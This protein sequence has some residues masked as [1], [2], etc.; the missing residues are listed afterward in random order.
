MFSDTASLIING[1]TFVAPIKILKVIPKHGKSLNQFSQAPLELNIKVLPKDC[2]ITTMLNILLYG[3]E[4]LIDDQNIL[5]VMALTT[6]FGMSFTNGVINYFKNHEQFVC[7]N[8]LECLT[9]KFAYDAF[10]IIMKN[11]RKI[12]N[13][14][15][16][17]R[18]LDE[19]KEKFLSIDIDLYLELIHYDNL[20]SNRIVCLNGI[21]KNVIKYNPIIKRSSTKGSDYYYKKHLYQTGESVLC[22][23]E[24]VYANLA[25][26]TNNVLSRNIFGEPWKNDINNLVVSGSFMLK[27]FL[28]RGNKFHN[29]DI[30][31]FILNSDVALA[32]E[33]C[34]YIAKRGG[35]DALVKK[36][37]CICEIEY[38]DTKFQII[39]SAYHTAIDVISSF[40]FDIVKCFFN[41]DGLYAH[42][43]FI[44]AVKH[45]LISLSLNI[46]EITENH[47]K[48]QQRLDKYCKKEYLGIKKLLQNAA[49]CPNSNKAVPVSES[50]NKGYEGIL[51]SK[52]T[53]YGNLCLIGSPFINKNKHY[54]YIPTSSSGSIHDFYKNLVIKSGM[55]NDIFRG[56]RVTPSKLV[57]YKKIFS[58]SQSTDDYEVLANN[59]YKSKGSVKVPLS[60]ICEEKSKIVEILYSL[61]ETINFNN[62]MNIQTP[63][64]FTCYHIQSSNK[65]YQQKIL[66]L[67]GIDKIN[68]LIRILE[69]KQIDA[70]LYLIA[71]NSDEL[72]VSTGTTFQKK[73]N[74]DP[75]KPIKIHYKVVYGSTNAFRLYSGDSHLAHWSLGSKQDTTAK[76]VIEFK[77]CEDARDARN[78]SDEIEDEAEQEIKSIRGA[79]CKKTSVKD[80]VSKKPVQ[81]SNYKR[82]AYYTEND[83]LV[84]A[85]RKAKE[86]KAKNDAIVAKEANN[87]RNAYYTENDKL[88]NAVRD[89]NKLIANNSNDLK[90]AIK[91]SVEKEV[92]KKS[93]EKNVNEMIARSEHYTKYLNARDAMIARS[94]QYARDI[95]AERDANEERHAL[96]AKYKIETEAK[97]M[98]ILQSYNHDANSFINAAPYKAANMPNVT[99]A[100]NT[101]CAANV[102]T[103]ATSN[104][105]HPRA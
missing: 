36:T 90:D 24:E 51:G 23:E 74:E 35:Q 64:T 21:G 84:N 55:S 48:L 2:D 37:G 22:S 91:K 33:L 88:V 102:T 38:D 104:F 77:Y 82:N 12:M 32:D 49:Q 86:L 96:S 15:D 4:H 27:C 97:N 47:N 50:P 62:S 52:A 31:L 63:E 20:L 79:M 53:S 7:A 66:S 94:E 100:A 1:T 92:I 72:K 45:M 16:Y 98:I 10:K 17:G 99:N 59:N 81:E 11:W 30:D 87:K 58:P 69:S 95:K 6:Y 65:V 78:L 61:L 29:G 18:Y 71:N 42:S 101:V 67:S 70:D 83:K 57:F 73:V 19:L 76:L 8:I 54:F 39:I 89:A 9:S 105:V 14:S 3:M 93:V 5:D 13:R 25:N 56:R 103:S 44:V 40:D 28:A 46:D 41:K 34:D 26:Y 80:I 68:F 43:N 75:K 60:A 85:A